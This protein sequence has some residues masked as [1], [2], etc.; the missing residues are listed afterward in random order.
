MITRRIASPAS[1]AP[2]VSFFDQRM[3]ALLRAIVPS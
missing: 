3:A 1:T 2:M